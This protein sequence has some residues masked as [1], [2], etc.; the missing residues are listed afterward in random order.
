MHRSSF[1][2]IRVRPQDLDII[3]RAAKRAGMTVSEY[4]RINALRHGT[5]IVYGDV[6]NIENVFANTGAMIAKRVKALDGLEEIDS[7]L[8]EDDLQ[9]KLIHA[10]L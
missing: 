9:L 5:A 2:Q 7:E 8:T 4:I 3:K 1:L 6:D 10:D